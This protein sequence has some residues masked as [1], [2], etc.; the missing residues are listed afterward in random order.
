MISLNLALQKRKTNSSKFNT[1]VE[2]GLVVF[3]TLSGAHIH[4]CLSYLQ[5]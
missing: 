1:V 2:Q 4:A 3:M 5:G